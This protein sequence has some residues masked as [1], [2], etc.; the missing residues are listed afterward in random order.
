MATGLKGLP[1]TEFGDGFA[2][3]ASDL[4]PAFALPSNAIGQGGLL[5]D[6]I[7]MTARNTSGGTLTAGTLV[8]VSSWV[9]STPLLAKAVASGQTTRATWV[10]LADIANNANG[11]I[12]KHFS[13]TGQNTNAATVGDVVY[14]G[15]TT[16]GGYAMTA[17]DNLTI[18]YQVVGRVAVKSATVGVIDFDILSGAPFQLVDRFQTSFAAIGTAA[19]AYVSYIIAP[20][21]ATI[22]GGRSVWPTSLAINGTNYVI[23][24]I[25][26][27]QGGA[28]N[29]AVLNVTPP[30]NSTFTAGAGIVADTAYPLTLNATPGNLVVAS[31]DI[32]KCVVTVVGT[33]G[34]AIAA[35]G[36]ISLPVIAL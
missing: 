34:A 6:Q 8:Y 7:G 4:D 21:P 26:N 32:L 36:K 35:G 16:P 19:G 23:V 20:Y 22:L 9:G 24:S 10:V 1:R 30:A 11:P 15:T 5:P 25:T 17:V 29:I 18:I 28:G 2:V 13:L 31:G 14:L 3:Q 27:V 33:L 12:G